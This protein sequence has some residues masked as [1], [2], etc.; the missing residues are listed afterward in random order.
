MIPKQLF[1]IWLGDNKPKYVDFAV[2]TFKDV[3]PDF[4]VDLMEWKIEDIENPK[5]KCL[6]EAINNIENDLLKRRPW[7]KNRPK[8]I[9]IADTYRY[10]LLNKYGG[11]YLDCDTF[12]VRPFDDSLLNH[13]Q[14][15][16]TTSWYRNKFINKEIFFIGQVNNEQLRILPKNDC[17]LWPH[18][19][20]SEYDRLRDKFFNCT[21]KYGEF[22]GDEHYYINHY[23]D[24]TWNP[25]NLRIQNI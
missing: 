22:Y 10:V 13:T 15:D 5:D 9:N 6:I 8:I 3:N 16:V 23:H 12:P 20:T 21:L 14:F 17:L 1:F 11:I 4:K 18:V 2:K 19:E 25:K 7:Y 24:F